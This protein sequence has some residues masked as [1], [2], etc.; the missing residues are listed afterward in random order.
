MR[1]VFVG[2]IC[3]LAIV[4]LASTAYAAV[5]TGTQTYSFTDAGIT[6]SYTPAE[7][8]SG[9]TQTLSVGST[10]VAQATVNNYQGLIVAANQA[11]P[12]DIVPYG[13]SQ[14]GA[15]GLSIEG[16]AGSFESIDFAS[17]QGSNMAFASAGAEFAVS[18]M[19]GSATAETMCPNC[20][21]KITIDDQNC[22][23]AGALSDD[24]TVITGGTFGYDAISDANLL[25]DD[26]CI[27]EIGLDSGIA[28]SAYAEGELSDD[29]IDCEKP[30]EA[31]LTTGVMGY[32]TIKVK[33]EPIPEPE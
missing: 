11:H 16:D 30:D 7:A 25:F 28:V 9:S 4:M 21:Q 6:T 27:D 13:V 20:D 3:A 23:Y 17:Q 10:P 15:T 24:E 14:Y 2:S 1:N 19:G 29:C 22:A 33:I 8:S 12:N 31:S 32:Q 18:A 5:I 26:G